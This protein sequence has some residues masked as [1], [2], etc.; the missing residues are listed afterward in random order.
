[1]FK[2]SWNYRPLCGQLFLSSQ[3][4]YLDGREP[5]MHNFKSHSPFQQT[6]DFSKFCPFKKNLS[7]LPLLNQN[8]TKLEEWFDPFLDQQNQN[9]YEFQ[10]DVIKS[11]TQEQ[12]NELRNQSLWEK[13]F[14]EQL[15]SFYFEEQECL[16]L[17]EVRGDFLS[18]ESQR[19]QPP[20][21]E[22]QT[23]WLD[24]PQTDLKLP[25]VNGIETQ[26]HQMLVENQY[27]FNET[28]LLK[29]YDLEVRHEFRANLCS[30]PLDQPTVP[31]FRNIGRSASV[32]FHYGYGKSSFDGGEN[33]GGNNGSNRGGSGGHWNNGGGDFSDDFL[34]PGARVFLYG[35]F[36]VLVLYLYNKILNWLA[37]QYQ[38]ALE[39]FQKDLKTL[40]RKN[41][42]NIQTRLYSIFLYSLYGLLSL[43]TGPETFGIT[44]RTLASPWLHP[45]LHAL[46][47]CL[48]W[49]VIISCFLGGNYY[50][51]LWY[52]RLMYIIGPA[53]DQTF[54][55]TV[56]FLAG[57]QNI[58][59][60][61]LFLEKL[62]KAGVCSLFGG[63]ICSYIRTFKLFYLK[64]RILFLILGCTIGFF[65]VLI[66]FQYIRLFTQKFAAI[67][68]VHQLIS[69][70]LGRF[71][72]ILGSIY[73]MRYTFFETPIFFSVFMYGFGIL[74]LAFS[75]SNNLF[76]LNM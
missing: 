5:G 52:K 41:S 23:D 58:A 75:A 27:P 22:Q 31:H 57:P 49:A 64:K 56:N 19:F 36:F 53:F 29:V 55:Q 35:L 68:T 30:N 15:E 71:S 39:D 59:L 18:D 46:R 44:L 9:L 14:Q 28:A 12:I 65:L 42:Q 48:R 20:H 50:G 26:K 38:K 60:P 69:C 67:P 61:I 25:F 74:T 76:P 66:D 51:L 43:F 24:V 10:Q 45:L 7:R 2:K 40:L 73:M 13:E 1:M 3:N 17:S 33:L 21:L 16:D 62:I 47:F 32:N 11:Q 54:D 34:N 72:L 6:S 37:K 63:C 4:P 8:T 70:Q